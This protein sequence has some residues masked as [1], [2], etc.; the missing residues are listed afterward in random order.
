MKTK[1]TIRIAR[2][3]DLKRIVEIYNEAIRSKSATGNM[4][5]FKESERVSWF[6][7]FD[8]FSFPIF[9]SELEGIV[10]GYATLSPYRPG[11]RAMNKV[12]EVSFYVD[13]SYHNKGVATSLLNHVL[14]ESNKIGKESLIAILLDINTKSVDLLKK[15]QFEEWGHLPNIID[16]EGK[17]CGHLIYGLKLSSLN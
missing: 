1:S 12:A 17:K 8:E 4:D 13:Y 3:D 11:R 10:V 6:N 7:N 2:S 14:L 15:F 9:V 5:E 16:F